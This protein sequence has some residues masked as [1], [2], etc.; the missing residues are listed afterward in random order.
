MFELDEKN[1]NWTRYWGSY[2]W[3]PDPDLKELEV[4][5]PPLCHRVEREE[6]DLFIES[7]AHTESEPTD[8]AEHNLDARPSLIGAW[9]GTYEYQ[10]R[11]R[12]SDGLVS[13][14]ITEHEDGKFEGLGIDGVGT[15]TVHGTIVDTKVIFTK[16]YTRG[17]EAWK[18][19]GV[20]NT[21]M[22]KIA[23]RWGPLDMEEDVAPVS[24]VEGSG[25]FNR[26]GEGIGGNGIEDREPS[27]QAPPCDIAITVE[28]PSGTPGKEHD[29]DGVSEAGSAISGAQTDA[30]EVLVTKGTF[31]LVQRPVDYFLYRPSDAEFQEGRPKALW[32]LARYWVRRWYRSR[33][34]IW[35]TLRERRDQR[36][37]YSA[38]FLKQEEQGTLWD[39]DEIAEWAKI[40]QQSHPNDLFMWRAIAHFKK[41]RAFSDM[42]VSCFFYIIFA[43][44]NLIRRILGLYA[45]TAPDL[46]VAAA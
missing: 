9:S 26:P 2:T 38:L 23:G 8:E 43:V 37:R 4:S 1:E 31:S 46:L 42:C 22:A 15:F 32:K 11:Y 24:A 41:T 33:H 13:F 28:G 35:D 34:L 10:E 17:G 40:I 36:N 20:L 29:D 5:E 25:P 3:L 18:Y 27:E 21:Q 16:S 7:S 19:V 44:I 6:L 39:P 30:T 45:T 12:Q 14:S